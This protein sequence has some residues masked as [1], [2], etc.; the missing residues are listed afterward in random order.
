MRWLSGVAGRSSVVGSAHPR[1]PVIAD[2]YASGSSSSAG[3]SVTPES[4]R[5][6]GAVYACV[7]LL[8]ETIAALPLNIYKTKPG[9]KERDVKHPLFEVLRW[10]TNLRQTSFEFREMLTGHLAIRGG[11]YAEIVLAKNRYDVGALV[12]LHPDRVTEFETPD[13]RVAFSY[14]PVTGSPRV[15]L[16]SEVLQFPGWHDSLEAGLS[17]ADG[18][19][20]LH[21][22]TL[23]LAGA[24]QAYS[25]RFFGNGAAPLGAI[26][27]PAV[28]GPEPA[29]KLRD[30]WEKRHQGPGNSNRLAILDGGMEWQSIGISNEAAQF[31]E[32]RK[33]SVIDICRIWKIPPHKIGS[34]D[35]ATFSNIEHQA[36]EFVT[37]TIL[38]LVVRMEARLNLSLLTQEQRQTNYIGFD[39]KGLL[40][41]DSTTRANFYRTMFGM[42]AMS[43][44][45]IRRLED[46]DEITG[47]DVF[48]LPLNLAPSDKLLE[49]LLAKPQ[50]APPGGP[51]GDPQAEP[52]A[53][54][55]ATA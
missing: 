7:R 43:Q 48:F 46:M 2:W 3:V 35:A 20:T 27:M 55:K 5:R 22:E 42:G 19:A 26:K 54:T 40:R 53:A 1:D 37:D 52:G 50:A 14:R 12:P 28:L 33:L 6:L 51:G 36:I 13:G 18:P 16:D 30:D 41:G 38:P 9:G 23:G 32:S 17:R 44:N 10:R 45:D 34:M 11:A 49:V 15:L 8:A 21:R 31:I 47:G 24:L 29:K 25:A 39:L 4:A